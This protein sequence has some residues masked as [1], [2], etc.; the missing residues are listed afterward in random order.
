MD[1][2]SHGLWGGV[3]FGRKS[4]KSFWLSFV[5]GILPDLIA[6]GPFF[7]L[8]FLRIVPRPNFSAEPPVPDSIP[9]FVYQVYNIS[10]S[11][12][13]FVLLFG[14]LWIILRRPL[15]EFSAWGLHI[16]MDIP[17]HSYKFF[18][19]PFLW[20]FSHFEINGH[21]WASPEILIPDVILLVILYIWFFARKRKREPFLV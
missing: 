21:P 15:W 12:F 17:T 9:Q 19:T 8:M 6:F 13:V 2:I 1:I 14:L 5:F 11:L 3:A 10:H 18:P 20:P 4:K 7:V 16:L